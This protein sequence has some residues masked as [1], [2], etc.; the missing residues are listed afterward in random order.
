MCEP[1]QIQTKEYFII[2]AD[3]NENRST[4]YIKKHILNVFIKGQPSYHDICSILDKLSDGSKGERGRETIAFDP[5]EPTSN[6]Y[7]W[8][9]P[10]HVNVVDALMKNV[11]TDRDYLPSR[12]DCYPEVKVP[13]IMTRDHPDWSKFLELLAGP[14]GCDFQQS[15][16]GIFTCKCS[17][18]K[19][20]PFAK[21]ILQKYWPDIDIPKTIDWFNQHNGR[22]DCTILLNID[23]QPTDPA[24]YDHKN[25]QFK[26]N[27]FT[28]SIEDSQIK[29]VKN[30][31]LPTKLQIMNWEHPDWDAFYIKL[32]GPE[33]CNYHFDENGEVDW[34][35]D[36]DDHQKSIAILRKYWPD[37]NIPATEEWFNLHDGECDCD[38]ISH[39]LKPAWKHIHSH[40]MKRVGLIM[41]CLQNK[42][43]P[44]AL[45]PDCEGLEEMSSAYAPKSSPN[46]D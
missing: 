19:E 11:L 42:V 1:Q 3:D 27:S 18:N 37:V 34:D 43:E 44:S 28:D 40:S 26:G 46:D 8:P 21:A 38:I 14:E 22:C 9:I 31:H 7:S 23:D 35:Y 15:E 45:P 41:E 29:E 5:Q 10:L 2:A 32:L 13:N 24:E 20:R 39:G 33:G 4:I 36:E 12:A 16:T 17:G 6:T 25:P 30:P